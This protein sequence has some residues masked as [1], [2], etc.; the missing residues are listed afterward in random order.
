[1]RG[2]HKDRGA[3]RSYDNVTGT[4][5]P[6]HRV[7]RISNAAGGSAARQSIPTWGDSMQSTNR[8]RLILPLLLLLTA[9]GCSRPPQSES[10]A[11]AQADVAETES[12]AG[13][14]RAPAAITAAKTAPEI[15][16][17]TRPSADQ[18]ASS[19]TTYTDAQR[20]FIRTAQAEFRVRD[21]YKSSL[22][23]E[24]VVAAQGGFVVKNHIGTETQGSQTRP[25]G[26][27]RLLELTEYT[28]RGEL[29]VRVPSDN[30]QAFL[31]A[32]VGQMEFLD[33]RNFEAMDAQF[34]LLRRQL[35]YRRS[36]EA[37]QQ[38]GRAVAEGGELIDKADVISAQ[39]GNKAARDE[40]LIAH[41]EFEDK[42]EFATIN[43]SMYQSPNV[44]QTELID[45]EAVFRQHRQGFVSRLGESLAAGWYG[46]L[47]V[48]LALMVLWPAWL[49]VLAGALV[50][51]RYRK[52]A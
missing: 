7:V 31:R 2:R 9:S 34:A 6:L 49:L 14:M 25:A 37:Q 52:P 33:Q 44:R 32:I 3:T 30:A 39:T 11:P 40:A 35:E 50:Y 20:K 38:L 8:S 45:V 22:A 16:T 17:D 48:L 27:G 42:I 26:N 47:D 10:A 15:E 36:Q 19:A 43:L 29:V 18:V 21:V 28:V 46:V 5:T 4:L 13:G 24:D 51:R 1:M 41:Q 23:I 12:T